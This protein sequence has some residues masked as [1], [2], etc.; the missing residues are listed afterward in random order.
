[1]ADLLTGC[2]ASFG[3]RP[4]AS[5]RRCTVAPLLHRK[6]Q[7]RW[8]GEAVAVEKLT[9]RSI[10]AL[11]PEPGGRLYLWDSKVKGLGVRCIGGGSRFFLLKYQRE[12]RQAWITLG[13]FGVLTV[14]QARDLARKELAKLA[15][16]KD[17][18][19]LRRAWKT[20]PTISELAEKFL[21]DHAGPKLK[22]TTL[23]EYRRQFDAI[24]LPALGK[25]RVSKVSAQDVARLHVGLEATPILSNRVHAL[26]SKLFN[27]AERWG[28]RP[29][30]SNPCL[31]HQKFTEQS[32][33]RFLTDAEL[34]RLGETLDAVDADRSELPVVTEAIRFLLFSGWRLNEALTLRWDAVDRQARLIRL[35]DTKSGAATVDINP[36]MEDVLDRLQRRMKLGNP[37]VFPGAQEGQHLVNLRKPW[38]RICKV[39]KIQ[40]VRLHDLR[41]TFGT[42]GASDAGLAHET[43][44][45]VLRHKQTSTTAIYARLAGQAR[46]GASE[47]IGEA[48]ARKLKG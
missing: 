25:L 23:R 48:M 12:G 7:G 39:A 4:Y 38:L 34:T 28:L 18:A 11:D 3:T 44:G 8:K 16:G 21:K 46:R 35:L 6:N 43:I 14:D 37:Y 17:P 31:G 13:E 29:H 33:E 5:F 30:G 32:R 42:V 36:A 10:E 22:P 19:A 15:D 2:L 45:K 9:K 20:D 24:I 47:K 40:G 26:L 27:T 41:R 1:M